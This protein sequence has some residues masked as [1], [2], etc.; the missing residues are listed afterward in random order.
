[1]LLVS[2]AAVLRGKARFEEQGLRVLHPDYSQYAAV[3]PAIVGW[4]PGLD[5]R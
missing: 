3:T 5:W 2:L 4:V 1:L